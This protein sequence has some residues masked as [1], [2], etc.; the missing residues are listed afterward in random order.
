MDPVRILLIA[1]FFLII[2]EL[3][4]SEETKEYFR[5]KP[6]D[7]TRQSKMPF[8]RLIFYVI[9]RFCTTT[10]KELAFFYAGISQSFYGELY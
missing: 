4:K 1:R 2:A 10:N 5:K 7:F 3:L 9:F 8:E 6:G